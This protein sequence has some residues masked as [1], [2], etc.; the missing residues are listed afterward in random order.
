MATAYMINILSSFFSRFKL[1]RISFPYCLKWQR[2][3]LQSTMDFSAGVISLDFCT[4][5]SRN[6][7]MATGHATGRYVRTGTYGVVLYV[8]TSR[9]SSV[10]EKKSRA[11]RRTGTYGVCI[12]KKSRTARR[13]RTYGVRMVRVRTG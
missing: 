1:I 8:G 13:T 12:R 10:L 7:R 3:E 4:Y 2:L 11:A 9:I 5:T 6:L